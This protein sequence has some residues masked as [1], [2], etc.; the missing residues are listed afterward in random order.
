MSYSSVR[1]PSPF[2]RNSCC[3][4]LQESVC[5]RVVYC[6]DLAAGP[7]C[8]LLQ[9]LIYSLGYAYLSSNFPLLSYTTAGT[10]VARMFTRHTSHVTHHTSH[11]TRHTSHVTRHTSHVTHHT[12]HVTRHTSHVTR[13]TS[14]VTRHTSHVTRHTSL[15]VQ[16]WLNQR[17]SHAAAGVR[18]IARN[19]F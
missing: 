14:H 2:L 13:H 4:L 16:R 11:I 17:S 12:S 7:C 18:V 15:S 9:Y 1:L 5:P 10:S 6:I 19:Y 3:L 8:C